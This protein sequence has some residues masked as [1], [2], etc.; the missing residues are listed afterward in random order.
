MSKAEPHF[1]DKYD[2]KESGK[3]QSRIHLGV[4]IEI[5]ET[6]SICQTIQISLSSEL[7]SFVSLYKHIMA[8]IQKR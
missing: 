5:R 7:L 1:K 4:E 3:K 8:T 2:N 6:L